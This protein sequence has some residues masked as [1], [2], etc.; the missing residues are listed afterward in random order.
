MA[1]LSQ[2]RSSESWSLLTN[3][4][5]F[6]SPLN[7]K[8]QVSELPGAKWAGTLTFDNL[9]G[10]EPRDLMA[11]FA[12]LRGQ[13]NT[14]TISPSAAPLRGTA[15]GTGVVAGGSQTGN[16]LTTDGW[17][18]DQATLFKAG[19]FF[20]VN[21]E[22]KMITETIASNSVGDATLVFEPP[23]RSSPADNASITVESPTCTVALTND[24]Q[25]SWSISS[26]NYHGF[27]VSFEERF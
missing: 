12:T 17:T 8:V 23:L 1:Y 20:E 4:Q 7:G 11:F 27:S 9:Q 10:D 6:V 2:T 25:S 24:Q 5:T 15:A 3:T 14:F 21:S 13:A 19:D 16:N 26:P 22:L 18:A